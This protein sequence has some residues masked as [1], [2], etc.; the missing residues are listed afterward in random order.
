VTPLGRD[1]K[2]PLVLQATGLGDV[3]SLCSV[4]GLDQEGFVSRTLLSLP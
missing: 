1:P 3:T 2:I 4:T